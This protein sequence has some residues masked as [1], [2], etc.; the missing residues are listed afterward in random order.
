M[1]TKRRMARCPGCKKQLPM[2]RRQNRDYQG[3]SWHYRCLSAN[4][5]EQLRALSRKR[6]AERREI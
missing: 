2:Q 6:Q 5:G 3:K 1:T 4:I